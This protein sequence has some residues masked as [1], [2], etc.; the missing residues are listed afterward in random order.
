MAHHQERAKLESLTQREVAAKFGVSRATLQRRL[1]AAGL[2]TGRAVR[3]STREIRD[4]L[5]RVPSESDDLGFT[6]AEID[7]LASA[8]KQ[9]EAA[10]KK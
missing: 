4:A 6:Q 5:E 2:P 10:S 1:H 8:L 7:Q 3:Y 9:F